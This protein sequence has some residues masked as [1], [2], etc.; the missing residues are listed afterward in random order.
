MKTLQ[1]RID[2]VKTQI[3]FHDK[4]AAYFERGIERFPANKKRMEAHREMASKFTDLWAFLTAVLL[5]GTAAPHRP[6]QLRLALTP[7]EIEGLPQE[8]L[9]ELS[10]SEADKADFAVLS[11]VDDAGGVLSLD[12]I[13]IGLYRKTGE[14]NKRTQV[15][16]RIYRMIQKGSMFPV[17][18][19]K[20][21]YSTRELSDEE[22]ENIS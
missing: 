15:N 19:K 13:L 8:L 22:A 12:K 20:G 3:Q 17:P 4:K 5:D 7:D 16:S 10:I 6:A 9:D 2:F 21:V 11:V 18:G 1:E 14:V